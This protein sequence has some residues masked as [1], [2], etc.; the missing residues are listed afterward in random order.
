MKAI[1]AEL[2][3]LNEAMEVDRF[4]VQKLVKENKL[5]IDQ[6]GEAAVKTIS[7]SLR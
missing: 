7:R 2:G 4:K 5:S 3:L 6:L 1:L